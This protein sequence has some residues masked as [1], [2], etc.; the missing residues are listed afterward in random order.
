M[1]RSISK[2]LA[3]MSLFATVALTAPN[4]HAQNLLVNG[5]FQAGAQTNTLPGWSITPGGFSGVS[6]I[7]QHNS[8]A[9]WIYNLSLGN[10]SQTFSTTPG[11][12]YQFEF[13]MWA[14]MFGGG[15]TSINIDGG[16]PFWWG[17][18]TNA[19]SRNWF[20]YEFVATGTSTTLNIGFRS[21]PNLGVI[22]VADASV[23][24]LVVPA[25][26]TLPVLLGAMAVSARRR[27][28]AGAIA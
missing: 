4:A 9:A 2:L 15:W 28:P 17:F 16:Q 21:T 27:R 13:Y 14:E 7:P 12:T 10:L 18:L 6:Y 3:P 23:V 11:N 24:E 26:A 5:N 25:P 20:R 8:W 22:Y 19:P 1:N